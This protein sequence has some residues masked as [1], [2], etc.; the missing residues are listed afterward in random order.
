[1]VKP[2]ELKEIYE[3]S[4]KLDSLFEE[5]NDLFSD[6]IIEKNILEL[7]VEFGELANETRCFKY[8]SIKPMSDKE[9]I[10]EEYIDCLFMIL[11]FCNMTNVSMDEAFPTA[12]QENIVGTFLTLYKDGLNLKKNLP[13]ETVKQLLV[14]ILYLAD[15]LNFQYE[16][17]KKGVSKKSLIIKKRFKEN[18]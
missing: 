6:E 4:K 17:I 9:V 8:W 18:Y 5:Q 7:L 2:I 12:T 11:C 13:K 16:D 3:E 14:N 1:M 15:L 10:L